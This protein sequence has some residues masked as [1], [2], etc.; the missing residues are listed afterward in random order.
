MPE[1]SS[2]GV[3]LDDGCVWKRFGKSTAPCRLCT[4]RKDRRAD[5]RGRACCSVRTRAGKCAVA[6]ASSEHQQR[7]LASA[8]KRTVRRR[9]RLGGMLNYYY[10]RPHDFIFWTIRGNDLIAAENG[11]RW[12]RW[13]GLTLPRL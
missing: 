13:L 5:R 10:A 7:C 3:A 1:T 9:E 11:L 2:T 6:V 4:R 12:I 8:M